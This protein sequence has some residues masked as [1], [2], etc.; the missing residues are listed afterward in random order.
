MAL[1]KIGALWK[2]KAK[3]SGQGYLSGTIEVIAGMKQYVTILPYTTKDGTEKK[4]NSPDYNILLNI[5]DKAEKTDS[6]DDT[7]DDLV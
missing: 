1:Q 2:K 5:E 7:K 3:D 4:P 6:K